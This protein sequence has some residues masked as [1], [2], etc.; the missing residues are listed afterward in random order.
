MGPST[1]C[2]WADERRTT[3]W[4]GDE[5]N[6]RNY[7]CHIYF[8]FFR[9]FLVVSVPPHCLFHRNVLMRVLLTI[10][11]VQKR[12]RWESEGIYET[13]INVRKELINHNNTPPT[14]LKTRKALLDTTAS[15]TR[16]KVGQQTNKTTK[17]E[18]FG[19]A[20]FFDVFVGIERN[21]PVGSSR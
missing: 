10:M 17:N 8:S 18:H 6:T 11:H 1:Q 12:Y 16:A 5:R 3:G 14:L 20:H 15:R 21:H 19:H 2:G 4:K 13:I 9:P 7:L